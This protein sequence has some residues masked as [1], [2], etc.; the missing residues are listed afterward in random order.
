MI[1]FITKPP[2]ILG[3]IVVGTLVFWLGC[4]IKSLWI[5]IIGVLPLCLATSYCTY[6]LHKIIYKK[7]GM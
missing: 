4:E 6:Q 7:I 5:I 3:A 1:K 2:I